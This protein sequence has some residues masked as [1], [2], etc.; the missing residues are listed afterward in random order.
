MLNCQ[1]IT[2]EG[3]L[4]ASLIINSSQFSDREDTIEE[5]F[6]STAI[7]LLKDKRA[8]RH[9]RVDEIKQ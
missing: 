9:L 6:H 4:E 8:T 3:K 1:I 7:Q 5:T 2:L